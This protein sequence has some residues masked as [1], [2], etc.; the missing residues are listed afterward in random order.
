[1]ESK[2]YKWNKRGSRIIIDSGYKTFDNQVVCI[3]TGNVI[4]GCQYSTYV[5]PYNE[6]ICNG[7]VYE[8]G[9]LR[10]YDMKY[11]EIPQY[12]NTNINIKDYIYDITQYKSCIVYQFSTYNNN[13]TKNI[14]GIIVEQDNEFKIF[15]TSYINY[16]KKQKCL[17]FIVKILKE[18][19]EEKI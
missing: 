18:E 7:N 13:N 12:L 1:M 15:N 5:R 4:G 10:D 17:E 2:Y 8:K 16:N 3:S 11:L 9:Y 14:F 19:R 6:T